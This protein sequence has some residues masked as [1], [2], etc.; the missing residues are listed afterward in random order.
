MGV[1]LA[2]VPFDLRPCWSIFQLFRIEGVDDP[3]DCLKVFRRND[4]SLL[5][6]LRE[7]ANDGED[8]RIQSGLRTRGGMV[9]WIR[10]IVQFSIGDIL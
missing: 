1:E 3:L 7:V 9:F 8:R 10:V 6:G 4:E 2:G 5:E